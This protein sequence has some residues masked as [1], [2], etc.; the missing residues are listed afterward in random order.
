VIPDAKA[1]DNESDLD[2]LGTPPQPRGRRTAVALIALVV[3]GLAFAGW[4]DLYTDW[5][6]YGSVG[7][8]TIFAT[9]LGT[10]IVLA[11]VV[12]LVAAALVYANVRLAL[13]LAPSSPFGVM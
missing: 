13:H 9:M 2:E 8:Q 1:M 4:A 11:L 7:Y 3:V 12:G 6:W 5:L 10:K